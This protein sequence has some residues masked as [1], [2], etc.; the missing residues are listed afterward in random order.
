MTISP[1]DA[2]HRTAARVAGFALLRGRVER[3]TLRKHDRDGTRQ[4]KERKRQLSHRDIT[5]RNAGSVK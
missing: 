1:I 2:V 3:R 5:R 4:G